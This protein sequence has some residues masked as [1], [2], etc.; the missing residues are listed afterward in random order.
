MPVYL[1]YCAIM[2]ETFR[3][4]FEGQRSK[5][6][7]TT[8]YTKEDEATDRIREALLSCISWLK[9]FPDSDQSQITVFTV[10]PSHDL[11]GHAFQFSCG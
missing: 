2:W 4:V 7:T 6:V 11:R 8:K 5:E 9:I 1:G 3:S 10:L